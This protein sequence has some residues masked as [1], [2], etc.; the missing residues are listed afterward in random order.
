[1]IFGY[2]SVSTYGQ[3]RDGNSLEVQISALKNAGAEKFFS[4]VFS[5][6][7]NNRPR[8]NKLIKV[9]HSGDTLIIIKLDRV[10]RGLIQ[11]IQNS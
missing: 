8:L 3:A 6:T 4:N 10:A 7:K 11:G 9:I 2:A 5:G 1:M